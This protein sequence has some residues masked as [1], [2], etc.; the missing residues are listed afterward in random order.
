MPVIK[1]FFSPVKCR[2]SEKRGK[3]ENTNGRIL[4]YHLKKKK[5]LTFILRLK[6]NLKKPTK[7]QNTG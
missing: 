3:E 1:I 4:C 6:I 7:Q 5:N 2:K